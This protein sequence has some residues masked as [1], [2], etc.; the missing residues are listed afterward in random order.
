MDLVKSMMI[1]ASG[2]RAQSFR[3]RIISEN[4]A[5]SQSVSS[6]PRVEPYRRKVVSFKNEVDRALG[7][8][9]VKIDKVTRDKAEF[10]QRYEP[11]HPAADKNGYVKLPN[12]NGLIETMDM[13]Q[14]QRS[15]EA[16]LNAIEA[17]KQMIIRTI[18]MLQE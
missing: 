10:G 14:A 1:S 5:N 13:Q 2:I 4:I 16:N 3:M 8:P 18:E 6:D 12:V 17:S 7:V 9:M 11:G 15:Y